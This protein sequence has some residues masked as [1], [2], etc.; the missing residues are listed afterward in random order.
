MVK[1]REREKERERKRERKQKVSL[2]L[3]HIYNVVDKDSFI[4]TVYTIISGLPQVER[5]DQISLI[6]KPSILELEISL[7]NRL[8]TI[9]EI[10]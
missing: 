5:W 7:I 3:V 9:T 4:I 6:I 2:I 8:F 1:E 10:I